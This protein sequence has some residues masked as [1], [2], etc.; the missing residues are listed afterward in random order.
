ML[1]KKTI[2]QVSK[3]TANVKYKFNINDPVYCTKDI[4]KNAFILSR[5]TIS[6]QNFYKIGNEQETKIYKESQLI[7]R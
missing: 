5:Y 2:I 3:N 4:I 1:G 6:G 7:H